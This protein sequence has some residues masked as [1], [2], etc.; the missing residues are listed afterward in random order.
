MRNAQ[1]VELE[2]ASLRRGVRR[3]IAQREQTI[4]WL[5]LTH[6]FLPFFPYPFYW[7]RCSFLETD[8][9]R[10]LKEKMN[11]PWPDSLEKKKA[12]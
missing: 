8:K 5:T 3:E 1:V 4:A 12:A 10:L 2:E 7:L 9:I 6:F 11:Q